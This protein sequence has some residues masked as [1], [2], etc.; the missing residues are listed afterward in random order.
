VPRFHKLGQNGITVIIVQYEEVVIARAG[1]G[2]ELSCLV[3]VDFSSGLDD[4]HETFMRAGA[5]K[6]GSWEFVTIS[7]KF[8][9]FEV[10]SDSCGLGRTLIFAALIKVALNHSC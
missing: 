10:R 9:W 4:G 8:F 6:D 7:P 5:G 1:R 2:Y 3:S